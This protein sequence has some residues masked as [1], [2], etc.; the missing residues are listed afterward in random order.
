[1]DEIKILLRPEFEYY[2]SL[3][4]AYGEDL[5]DKFKQTLLTAKYDDTSRVLEFG[6]KSYLNTSIEIIE[7]GTGGILIKTNGAP[8]VEASNSAGGVTVTIG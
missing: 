6:S 3:L 8:Y 7:D 5:V 4:T 2:H 1:M